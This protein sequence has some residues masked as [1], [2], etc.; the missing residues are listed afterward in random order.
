MESNNNRNAFNNH[1]VLNT[2]Q[3]G[4][5]FYPAPTSGS[6]VPNNPNQGN[7][8]SVPIANRRDNL[9][10]QITNNAPIPPNNNANNVNLP[11]QGNLRCYQQ[12]I[13]CCAGTIAGCYNATRQCPQA[14][15]EC[16]SCLSDCNCDCNCDCNIF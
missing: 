9:N 1:N 2:E 14:C 6:G 11:G 3:V 13:D 5:N 12:A 8:S 15:G 4:L 10:V 16:A 7:L